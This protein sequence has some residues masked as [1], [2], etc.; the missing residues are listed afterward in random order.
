MVISNNFTTFGIHNKAE[1]YFWVAQRLLVLLSSPIG[2]TLILY[3]SFQKKAFHINNFV[4]TVMLYIA[5]CDLAYAIAG[6]LPVAAS[7][8]ANHWT[9]GE[10]TCYAKAYFGR[11]IYLVGM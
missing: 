10:V 9:L 6:V 7:M 4:L 5:V 11:Y 8:I 2:D 1:R 3:A